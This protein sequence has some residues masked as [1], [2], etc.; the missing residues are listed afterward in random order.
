MHNSHDRR[1]ALLVAATLMVLSIGGLSSDE[2]RIV[3]PTRGRPGTRVSRV[4]SAG[5]RATVDCRTANGTFSSSSAGGSDTGAAITAGEYA[6]AAPRADALVPAR[7]PVRISVVPR[8]EMCAR[9]PP[10]PLSSSIQ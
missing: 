10:L 4:R 2:T 7:Q 3:R 9:P 1:S 6:M 5:H 8:L